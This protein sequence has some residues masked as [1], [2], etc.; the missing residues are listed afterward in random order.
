MTKPSHH[1][2]FRVYTSRDQ[3]RFIPQ[4]EPIKNRIDFFACPLDYYVYR[5]LRVTNTGDTPVNFS[6]K[7]RS[8]FD[9]SNLD[10]DDTF[11]VQPKNGMLLR[12][13][14]QIFVFR[15][16]PKDFRIFESKIQFVFNNSPSQVKCT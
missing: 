7:C 11:S 1:H 3:D 15:F 13:R 9:H 12:Q 14:S 16:H 2:G 8:L 5:T 4:L 6:I 10:K